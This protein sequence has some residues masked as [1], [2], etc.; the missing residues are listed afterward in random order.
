[1]ER[2][3]EKEE[4]EEEEEE[5]EQAA[6]REEEGLFNAKAIYVRWTLGSTLRTRP[7]LMLMR[8]VY[9]KKKQ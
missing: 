2:F 5:E 4:E 8:R 7:R 9:L 1:M 6:A 3:S